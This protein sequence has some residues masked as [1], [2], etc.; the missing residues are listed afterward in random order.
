MHPEFGIFLSSE[1]KHP[2][3]MD[4]FSDIFVL[5]YSGM[6]KNTDYSVNINGDGKA[7]SLTIKVPFAIAT[8]ETLFQVARINDPTIKTCMHPIFLGIADKLKNLKG[9]HSSNLSVWRKVF[10][11]PV[12]FVVERRVVFVECSYGEESRTTILH[13]RGRKVRDNYSN[14]IRADEDEIKKGNF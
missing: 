8:I 9:S 10:S 6:T 5:L 13:I 4:E 7:L 1:W 12:P 14:K 2:D 11:I 3:T